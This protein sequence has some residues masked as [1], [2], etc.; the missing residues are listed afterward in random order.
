MGVAQ[1]GT[2]ICYLRPM[3]IDP[4]VLDRIPIGLGGSLLDR[5]SYFTAKDYARI[6]LNFGEQ[7]EKWAERTRYTQ[8]Q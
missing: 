6:H 5:G 1:P 7:Y 2:A 3:L 8:F 4:Q